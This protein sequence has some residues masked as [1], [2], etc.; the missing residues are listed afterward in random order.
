MYPSS[1]MQEMVAALLA[2]H[3]PHRGTGPT[4][5]LLKKGDDWLR[6]REEVRVLHLTV[7]HL[8]CCVDD[9]LVTELEVHFFIQN[10]QWFPYAIY[11]AHS[12]LRSYAELDVESRTLT[13]T[14]PDEQETLAAY[15]DGWSDRLFE[16]AWLLKGVTP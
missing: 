5:L 13:V 14:H 11:R 6:I 3:Q 16:E 12:G 10:R 1:R 2:H 15:C 9:E 4:Y 8:Y 7:A